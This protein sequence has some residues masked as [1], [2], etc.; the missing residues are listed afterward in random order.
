M[1]D[2]PI[3]FFSNESGMGQSL[4]VCKTGDYV[5][6]VDRANAALIVT[7]V[8]EHAA[9]C[10]VADASETGYA[11]LMN[12]TNLLR[13]DFTKEQVASAIDRTKGELSRFH[14]AVSELAA[15]RAGKAT[16]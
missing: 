4:A 5:G 2:G 9:L 8:N 12:V 16:V 11:H 10:A 7:A 1:T 14:K 13:S 6:D 15:I 3:I